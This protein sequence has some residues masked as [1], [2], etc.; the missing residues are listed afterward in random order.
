MKTYLLLPHLR[1][2]GANGM[3]CA[4]AAGFPA[5]TAFLGFV[6][7][8]ENKIGFAKF[9]KVGLV[10]HKSELQAYYQE[11]SY[12][13]NLKLRKAPSDRNGNAS[14]IIEQALIHMEISLLIE[15][16]GIQ[17]QQEPELLEHL[18]KILPMMRIA[19]GTIL[20]FWEIPDLFYVEEGAHSGQEHEEDSSI[21]HEILHRL[22]L[23]YALISRTDL[24]DKLQ[25]EGRGDALDRILYAISLQNIPHES[26]DGTVC[27]WERK[28]LIPG[29]LVPL[30]VGFHDLS[31][32]IRV[33]EQRAY[34]REHHFAEP[35]LTLCEFKMPYHFTSIDEMMW[36]YHYDSSKGNYLCVN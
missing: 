23:G 28:K 24:M 19:G 18:R 33:K 10:V 20:G 5:M 16:D 4:Y 36:Q 13:W 17:P 11:S 8:L 7:A 21:P 34:H 12:C 1:I 35:L 29:W 2:H 30:A 27:E 31:G 32:A 25:K 14:P 9:Q 15:V 3:S 22:M 26:A 6:Q